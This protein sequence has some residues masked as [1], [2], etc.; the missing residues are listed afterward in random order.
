M[1]HWSRR[2]RVVLG[3]LRTARTSGGRA[4]KR[5]IVR[6][7]CSPTGPRDPRESSARDSG[8]SVD[9]RARVPHPTTLWEDHN[10]RGGRAITMQRAWRARRVSRRGPGCDPSQGVGGT[11]APCP[12]DGGGGYL[13]WRGC[14]RLQQLPHGHFCPCGTSQVRQA[15]GR[16]RPGRIGSHFEGVRPL[17]LP[18]AAAAYVQS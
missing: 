14:A 5:G 11:A 13:G 10:A 9:L 3:P 7:P 1:G 17:R 16:F 4:G 18:H 2:D 12:E 8:W 15:H 6:S